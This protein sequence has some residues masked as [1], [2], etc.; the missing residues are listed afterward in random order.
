M[1]TARCGLYVIVTLIPLPFLFILYEVFT[2]VFTELNRFHE[3]L[4]VEPKDA[5]GDNLVVL[6]GFDWSQPDGLTD[7]G[8]L[9]DG[10]PGLKEDDGQRRPSLSVA[11]SRSHWHLDGLLHFDPAFR[12]PRRSQG[13]KSML[14]YLQCPSPSI[15]SAVVPA[16]RAICEGVSVVVQASSGVN[17]DGTSVR[18]YDFSCPAEIVNMFSE[19]PHPPKSEG[20]P[21]GHEWKRWGKP[22]RTDGQLN[23]SGRISNPGIEKI[24]TVKMEGNRRRTA[25]RPRLHRHF[26]CTLC[27]DG[28]IR[29]YPSDTVT[30]RP[31][32]RDKGSLRETIYVPGYGHPQREIVRPPEVGW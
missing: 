20:L 25:T 14:G 1:N 31:V 19:L 12:V 21:F 10:S 4:N 26:S 13:T 8:H 22:P 30:V 29:G 2:H 3:K 11:P 23:Q 16:P 9:A 28:R 17:M 15:G 32:E 24:S 5:W 18:I 6:V 7:A 27:F